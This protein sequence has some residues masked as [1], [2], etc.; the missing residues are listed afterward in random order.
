[1]VILLIKYFLGLVKKIKIKDQPNTIKIKDEPS[2]L[3]PV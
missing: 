3:S 2:T 1:M